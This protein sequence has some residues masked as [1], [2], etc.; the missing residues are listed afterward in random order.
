MD[1]GSHDALNTCLQEEHQADENAAKKK[2]EAAAKEEVKQERAV[3][4]R[5][6]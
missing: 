6:M 3:A 4:T 1:N 2:G 5:Y